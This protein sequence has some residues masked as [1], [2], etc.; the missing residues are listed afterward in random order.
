MTILVPRSN[1][2]AVEVGCENVGAL[3]GAFC[4]THGTEFTMRIAEGARHVWTGPADVRSVEVSSRSGDGILLE[5]A[6]RRDLRS[7]S[8]HTANTR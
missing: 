1:E 7:L 3:F 4:E 8:P 2:F 5:F 6:V